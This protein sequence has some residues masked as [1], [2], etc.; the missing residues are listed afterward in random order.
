MRGPPCSGKSALLNLLWARIRTE[1][2]QADIHNIL[3]W[4]EPLPD[5][6]ESDVIMRLTRRIPG[7]P[8]PSN[9]TYLLFDNGQ[10][11]YW[12][13]YLWETFFKSVA[14]YDKY[15]VIL[16]CSYGSAG[17]RPLDY[18]IGT[19]M[20]LS[21]R[22]RVSL[23]PSGEQADEFGSIGLL[24]TRG[25]FDEVIERERE[26]ALDQDLQ[27][28][29]FRW[30]GGHAGA[31]SDVL[32]TILILVSLHKYIRVPRLTFLLSASRHGAPNFWERR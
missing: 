27:D 28:Q 32:R 26:L 19:P 8:N 24:F 20:D 25:E 9:I 11:T 18:D 5:T 31:V 1:N 23:V 29:I 21:P 6:D 12:D 10:A 7:Y 4:P 16:F 15:K 3:V 22:A 17:V 13:K 2:P 30:T 14:G